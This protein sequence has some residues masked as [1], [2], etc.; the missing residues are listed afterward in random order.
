MGKI[1]EEVLQ[2]N[3]NIKEA[4]NQK[5]LSGSRDIESIL[6][7][8]SRDYFIVKYYIRSILKEQGI[9][10]ERKTEYERTDKNKLETRNLEIIN[11]FNNEVDPEIIA[12]KFDITPTRVRQILRSKLGNTFKAS[13]NKLNA[14]LD[15]IKQDL[16]DGIP[17]KSIVK[18]YG[19]NII[20]QINY[21]LKFNLFKESSSIKTKDIIS[22]SKRGLPPKDIALKHNVTRNYIYIILHENG[23][24]YNVKDDKILRDKKIIKQKKAGVAINEIASTHKITP[25][26]V[27]IILSKNK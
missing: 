5:I 7:D 25:T 22:M 6:D 9:I 14:T 13:Y 21:N 27:R 16:T 23:I 15:S 11:L 26:M 19:K 3:Q 20:K 18:K 2:R 24:R 8:L 4:Y 12:E 17:Y 1:R 10:I